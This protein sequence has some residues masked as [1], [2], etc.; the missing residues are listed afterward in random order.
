MRS[1]KV[2]VVWMKWF[3]L[4]AVSL[5]FASAM[6]AQ[7]PETP[8]LPDWSIVEKT[9]GRAGKLDNGVYKVT[10]PR[11]D[12]RVRVGRTPVDP[13]AALVSWIAFRRD[14]SG[15]VTNGDLALLTSELDAAV[16]ALQQHGIEVTAIHNHLAGEIPRIMYVHF[17]ARGELTALTNALKSALAATRTPTSSA[18]PAKPSAISFGQK[19]IEEIMGKPGTVSGTVLS[20]SFG[21]DYPISMHATDLPPQMGMATV[22]NF[23]PALKGV[24]A[25]GDFVVRER[26]VNPVISKLRAGG[27]SV[28]AVHNHMLDDEPRMVFIHF[29]AEGKP[30]TV[31]FVLRDALQASR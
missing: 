22:M 28:T 23:Q 29:W 19:R 24:A 2:G 18:R 27:I 7:V 14:T 8:A 31:A 16:N 1:M 21:H 30:D 12:L 26:Q 6:L 25:T 13:A 20:F 4:P 15:V 9:L 10:F 3:S 5:L 17:F 11:S